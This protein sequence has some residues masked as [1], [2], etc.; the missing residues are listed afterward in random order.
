V[1]LRGA[2]VGVGAS[3]VDALVQRTEGWPA[4]LYL[5][6]LAMRA[7]SPRADAGFSVTGDD[8]FVGDYLRSELLDRVSRAEV[9]FLTR[10]SILD[11]MCGGLCDAVLGRTGSGWTLAS[12]ES[13]NLLV[14]PLDRRRECDIGQAVPADRETEREV[15]QHLRGVVHRQPR[16]PP[17]HV[18]AT[19][20]AW[21]SP[22]L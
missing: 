5:A 20:R 17:C 7:G 18:S 12:L 1:L 6:A 14:V 9:T 8:R 19:D 15:Q 4:G 22:T 16:S 2:G 3:D 10:T 13:R 21:S 11:R